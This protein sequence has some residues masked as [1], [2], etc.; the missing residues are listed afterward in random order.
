MAERIRLTSSASATGVEPPE[1][2]L[3]FTLAHWNRDGHSFIER[4]PQHR[5]TYSNGL[6]ADVLP[7]DPAFGSKRISPGN[8]VDRVANGL[9]TG[10]SAAR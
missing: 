10:V 5:S 6:A 2:F 7:A 8:P 3:R 4:G 9:F 1:R